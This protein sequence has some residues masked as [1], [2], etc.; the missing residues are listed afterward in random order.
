VY[1]LYSGQLF[2]AAA[3]SF[4]IAAALDHTRLRRVTGFLM[5][6]SVPLAVLAAPP[7]PI[8]VAIIASAA[9]IAALVLRGKRIAAAIAIASSVLVMAVE[10]PY[11]VRRPQVAKPREAFVVGDSL[12]S[13]GFGEAA[14]WPSVLARE[15]GVAVTNLALPSDDASMALRNQIPQLPSRPGAAVIVEIG[16]NDMLAGASAKQFAASLDAIL[17]AAGRRDVILLELP[18][19]PGRWSYGAAQ[20]RLA[21]KHG[22]V[23]VPKRLLARVLTAP[24]NTSDGVHLRQAGHD[25][26]ARELAEWLGW[27]GDVRNLQSFLSRS[28]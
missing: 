28:R 6:L 1:F 13:G 17:I 8:A 3:A 19:I 5:L 14:P 7:L 15:T 11:H 25:E 20:R 22:A 27:A 16:G 12:A 4:A 26:L 9:A 10:A 24:G 18:L 23:L 2:F 21:A